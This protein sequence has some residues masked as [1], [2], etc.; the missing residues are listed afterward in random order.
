MVRLQLP[1]N[2]LLI[3]CVVAKIPRHLLPDLPRVEAVFGPKRTRIVV[4][5]KLLYSLLEPINLGGCCVIQLG[6]DTQEAVLRFQTL[7]RD[8]G[9]PSGRVRYDLVGR[10]ITAQ[11]DC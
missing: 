1:E 10:S 7:R 5:A 8:Y 2:L 3:R 6:C 4:V 9:R 11:S